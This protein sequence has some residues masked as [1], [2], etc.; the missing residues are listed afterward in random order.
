MSPA[1]EIALIESSLHGD[2]SAFGQIVEHYQSL[3]CSLAFSATGD[4]NTS[5]DLAQETFVAAWQQLSQLNEPTKFRSWLCG[6]TRNLIR[7]HFRRHQSRLVSSVE[8][9][10]E[11]V[12]TQQAQPAEAALKREEQAMLWELLQG[13]P[14]SY[15]EPLVLYY[16]EEQSVGKVAEWLSLSE[17]AVKQRLSRGRNLLRESVAGFVETA[18]HSSKPGK[19]FVAGVLA[20]LPAASA[21]AMGIG[22]AA[23]TAKGAGVVKA[24]AATPGFWAVLLG[25]LLGVLGAVFGARASLKDARSANE[26]RFLWKMIGLCTLLVGLLLL[27]QLVVR[28]A[29]PAV[30]VMPIYQGLT[31]SVYA[32]LLTALIIWGNRRQRAIREQEG[33]LTQAEKERVIEPV[34]VAALRGSLAGSMFGSTCWIWITGGLAG[35]WLTVAVTFVATCTAWCWLSFGWPRNGGA[36][37]QVAIFRASVLVVGALSIVVVSLRWRVWQQV[38][39]LRSMTNVSPWLVNLL[40]VVLVAGLW[41]LLRLRGRS[42]QS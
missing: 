40:L 11:P 17:D 9:L 30:F 12:D 39:A 42:F 21:Q 1:N 26:R 20:L 28:L 19:A 29:A 36:R 18:L 6:I 35:D 24:A 38:P 8:V 41:M 3:V 14:E 13:I 31:W 2:R 22:L 4:L 5:E 23:T 25:P 7:G 16:R 33:T 34:S 15:R 27:N 10:Q 37:N 32:I